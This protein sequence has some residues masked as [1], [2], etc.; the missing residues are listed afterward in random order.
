MINIYFIETNT[1][2]TK[3]W[4]AQIFSNKNVAI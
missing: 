3:F 4:M 1:T 2:N